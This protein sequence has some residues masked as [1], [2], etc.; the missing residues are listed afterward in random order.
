MDPR[1]QAEWQRLTGLSES[2][3]LTRLSRDAP[4][5]VRGEI[6]YKG[7]KEFT[8]RLARTPHGARDT[9]IYMEYQAVVGQKAEFVSA[10]VQARGSKL[11]ST[12]NRNFMELMQPHGISRL[13]LRAKDVGGYHW[14]RAGFAPT[15]EE[16]NMGGLRESIRHRLDKV[17]KDNPGM[18]DRSAEKDIRRA[19]SSRDPRELWKIVDHEAQVNGEKV[20]KLL[21][22]DMPWRGECDLT[23]P[24]QKARFTAH[25]HGQPPPLVRPAQHIPVRAA[26]QA[27]TPKTLLG[28]AAAA[29]AVSTVAIGVWA[30]T[31]TKAKPESDMTTAAQAE[32]EKP[33]PL[34]AKPPG[35]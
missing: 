28:R 35:L 4:A 10:E 3:F 27:L 26:F 16:W 12:L 23:N 31:D 34:T 6:D 25:L 18:L 15:H 13:E 8:V 2:E 5:G 14:A 32:Q 33:R 7:G 19:L 9:D 21:M 29:L 17:V 22:V 1:Y 24:E 11:T 20:G 30:T